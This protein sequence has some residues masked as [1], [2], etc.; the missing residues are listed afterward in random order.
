[1]RIVLI[2]ISFFILSL[3]SAKGQE[4]SPF[5]DG[6]T[7]Y[8]SIKYGFLLGGRGCLEIKH[9][10]IDNKQ[11]FH[12]K[13]TGKTAGIFSLYKI[14]DIYES[15]IDP[16]TDLPIKAIRNIREGNYRRYDVATFDREN[17]T[18]FSSRKNDTINV[19]KN[20]L[21]ILSIFYY[22]RKHLSMTSVQI[23]DTISFNTYF[24][25]EPFPIRILYKGTDTLKTKYGRIPCYEFSP[26]IEVDK[27]L[28]EKDNIKVYLSSDKNRIPVKVKFELFIGSLVCELDGF[29]GLNNSFK[30]IVN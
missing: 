19:A 27:V 12:T 18:V 1:M 23:G 30:V 10:T 21:D 20:A 16:Q 24:A 6:E 25:Q 15:F 5:K 3:C 26:L 14:E 4:S 28:Q 22:A 7:L 9:D 13:A 11:V 2:Y 17:N 8:Y 29:K